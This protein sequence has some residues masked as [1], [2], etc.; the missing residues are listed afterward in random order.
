MLYG[1]ERKNEAARLLAVAP[2]GAQ[3]RNTVENEGVRL[4]IV[5]IIIVAALP[6]SQQH[7]FLL[8][9]LPGD[10]R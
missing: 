3:R 6:V 8:C 4:V 2:G 7:L 5:V 1:K 9:I 10:R